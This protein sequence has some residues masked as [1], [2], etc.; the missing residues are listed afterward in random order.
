MVCFH[1]LVDGDDW[2]LFTVWVLLVV[3][4]VCHMVVDG[5]DGSVSI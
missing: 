1:M 3:M 2:W 5:C 4:G